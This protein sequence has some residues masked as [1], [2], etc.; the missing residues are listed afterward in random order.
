MHQLMSNGNDNDVYCLQTARYTS[1]ECTSCFRLSD[2]FCASHAYTADI[3]F[4]ILSFEWHAIVNENDKAAYIVCDNIHNLLA[5][6]TL[7]MPVCNNWNIDPAP[8]L[9]NLYHNST[10]SIKAKWKKETAQKID[11]TTTRAIRT[12]VLLEW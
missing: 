10:C 12:C 4:S 7:T 3:C 11:K 9:E 6:L 8:N 1:N 5:Q 2:S